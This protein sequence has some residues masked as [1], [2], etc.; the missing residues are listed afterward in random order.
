MALTVLAIFPLL[1]I[2]VYFTNGAVTR[3]ICGN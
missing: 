1:G 3:Y 2:T